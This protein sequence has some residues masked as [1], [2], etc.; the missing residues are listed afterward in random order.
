MKLGWEHFVW[1]WRKSFSLGEKSEC[2]SHFGN[3][4]TQ[5]QERI[6]S[7]PSIREKFFPKIYVSLFACLPV[8]NCMWFRF[9]AYGENCDNWDELQCHKTIKQYKTGINT[10]LF[11]TCLCQY[12]CLH[13]GFQE[14]LWEYWTYVRKQPLLILSV[15]FSFDI[16]VWDS[17]QIILWTK[18]MIRKDKSLWCDRSHRTVNPYE[19]YVADT[20]DPVEHLKME[21]FY[22]CIATFS[23]KFTVSHLMHTFYWHPTQSGEHNHI[24]EHHNIISTQIT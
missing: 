19:K 6:D 11:C 7:K 13:R 12:R 4:V 8:C 23:V 3:T 22:V 18:G 20:K 1:E 9:S 21:Q 24:K 17:L 5:I 15:V 10:V 16:A 14:D 2:R